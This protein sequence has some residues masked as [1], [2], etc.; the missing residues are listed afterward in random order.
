MGAPR[1][2]R[3]AAAAAAAAMIAVFAV[4]AFAAPLQSSWRDDASDFDINRLQQ[5]D[6]WRE[7]AVW[8]AQHYA[9]GTGDFG[10]LRAALEPQGPAVPAR[11]HAP[12]RR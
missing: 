4:P 5:M 11:P 8:E 7:R 9:D 3:I 6:Q 2:F 12:A 1:K 10:A